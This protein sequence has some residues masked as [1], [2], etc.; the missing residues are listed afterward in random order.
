M[1]N[2]SKMLQP[3]I[4]VAYKIGFEYI[5]IDAWCIMRDDQEDW[6]RKAVTIAVSQTRPRVNLVANVAGG[7]TKGCFH[8]RTLDLVRRFRPCKV[9]GAGGMY[10]TEST[11]LSSGAVYWTPKSR[12]RLS[13]VKTKFGALKTYAQL[14]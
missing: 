11:Y 1:M 12:G 10:G 4:G 9:K 3:A 14:P 7:G 6:Q 8:L 13:P 2:L 5:W